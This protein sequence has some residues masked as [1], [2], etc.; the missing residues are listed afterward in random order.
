MPH[1]YRHVETDV[2]GIIQWES[3]FATV[4]L[5]HEIAKISCKHNSQSTL[6][7]LRQRCRHQCVQELNAIKALQAAIKVDAAGVSLVDQP[8]NLAVHD[9]QKVIEDLAGLSKGECHFES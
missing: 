7:V 8:L 6:F 2:L 4:M 3:P 5:A 9:H 1:D